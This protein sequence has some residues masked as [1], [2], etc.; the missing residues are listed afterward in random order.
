MLTGKMTG[1]PPSAED[2]RAF[3]RHGEAFDNIETF[4]GVDYETGTRRG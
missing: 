4:S 1:K 3:N 2:H